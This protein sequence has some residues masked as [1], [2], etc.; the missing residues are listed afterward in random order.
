M[1]E[2]KLNGKEMNI[3]FP[4]FV[5]MEVIRM[6]AL[7]S[8]VKRSSNQSFSKVLNN[9]HNVIEQNFKAKSKKEI[10][11]NI[12][13]ELR[14]LKHS[15]FLL[16][17]SEKSN[18]LLNWILYEE[19]ELL[20]E[21]FNEQIKSHVSLRSSE[22]FLTRRSKIKSV[23]GDDILEEELGTLLALGTGKARTSIISGKEYVS[24]DALDNLSKQLKLEIGMVLLE[25][26]DSI[27]KEIWKMN[28][29][30]T[31][32]LISL[33]PQKTTGKADLSVPISKDI[34][35]S[36]SPLAQKI[37]T[38]M[39]GY[40]FSLKNYSSISENG[41]LKNFKETTLGF[42]NSNLYKSIT[43]G[44]SEYTNNIKLQNAIFFRGLQYLKETTQP[45]DTSNKTEVQQ[46][47]YHL[48]A[49]YEIK[50]SGQIYDNQDFSVDF[51]I[52]ND[53]DSENIYVRDTNSLLLQNF[54]NAHKTN[55]L[56][57]EVRLTY[58]N[59]INNG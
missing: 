46:H 36:A 27:D 6:S 55:S 18:P 32:Q 21:V 19:N 22:S 2:M 9:I 48:K 37:A 29:E 51:I 53:P 47:F 13:K 58:F 1:N 24:S 33:F 35:I 10:A 8:Y 49:Y 7:A 14:N 16:K 20:T 25:Y 39:G 44:L 23:I 3:S 45:P 11:Q 15:A 59:F 31:S 30:G 42:G 26:A 57:G 5:F 54:I 12:Q 50:G 4:F 43:G 17:D 56:L 28:P 40:R 38:L 52:W 34:S 41:Q